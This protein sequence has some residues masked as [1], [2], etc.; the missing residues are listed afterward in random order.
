MM[1]EMFSKSLKK[2]KTENSKQNCHCCNEQIEVGINLSEYD[3]QS[4]IISDRLAFRKDIEIDTVSLR[5]Q[6]ERVV[7]EKEDN[8]KYNI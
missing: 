8:D 1:E 3:T 6:L 4:C 7:K 2:K 5:Q